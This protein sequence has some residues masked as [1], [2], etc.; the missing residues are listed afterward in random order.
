MN[1][2]LECYFP[3]FQNTDIF[4]N[5]E[6][7]AGYPYQIVKLVF[8]FKAQ[9]F[10]YLANSDSL[11]KMKYLEAARDCY[12]LAD[13][14]IDKM[15]ENI[16]NLDDL[17]A[18]SNSYAALY[19]AMSN[20]S[21]QLY[22]LSA[23]EEN[24]NSAL[25]YI[26]KKMFAHQ[27]NKSDAI[28]WKS[29]HIPPEL[30]EQYEQYH[31]DINTLRSLTLNNDKPTDTE[32]MIVRKNI[33]Q[34]LFY[35]DLM[36][37]YS[38]Q[39]LFEDFYEKITL[40][41]IQHQ[42]ADDEC[43]LL[44]SQTQHTN[45]P[46]P[47]HLTIIAINKK[48]AAVKFVEGDTIFRMIAAYTTM[49]SCDTSVQNLLISG[50]YLYLNLIFPVETLLTK[51]LI[52]IPSPHLHQLSFDALPDP[53]TTKNNRTP[54]LIE[55]HLIRKEFSLS[56]FSKE[57]KSDHIYS[58][59]S[60]LAV[61]PA[62][63]I[64]KTQQIAM[65]VKRDTSLI[66]LAGALA[67]CKE[68][69]TYFNTR[70]LTGFDAKENKFKDL[71]SK[72]AYLHISTHGVPAADNSQTIQLAFSSPNENKEDGW[73]NFY[74]I[75][76]LDLHTEMVV[77]SACKTGIGKTNNG[78]GNLNLAWAFKQAGAKSAIISL[79]DVNDFASAEIMPSLYQ[80]IKQGI[81]RPE[82]LRLA[83]LNYLQKHD[84]HAAHPYYWA[85]FDYIG[86]AGTQTKSGFLPSENSLIRY[87]MLLA[88]LGVLAT[89]AVQRHR[90]RALK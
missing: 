14:I 20:V 1:K 29:A 81:S 18:F 63:N 50:K 82:A 86:D 90:K 88:S 62:F 44:Y 49:L 13:E 2:I 4:Q 19:E 66:N 79:W 30:I 46:Y 55:N 78:E 45:H 33:E 25:R 21:L 58:G 6:N 39:T 23:D 27:M 59:D 57:I 65:M 26:S 75:L 76:N 17:L 69:A 12:K 28:F 40:T 37:Q 38:H 87:L 22:T 5:P 68:I 77:L 11:K 8:F 32:A 67:E 51:R 54:W 80:N 73:L 70:L 10:A 31:Q 61:A 24:L 15:R 34:D 41:K 7:A 16:V 84:V 64:E 36:L 60:L 48:Q 42:L 71:S 3:D 85:G 74:E 47:N 83:K 53:M 35:D 56:D 89:L 52:V 9:T 72:F 43:L